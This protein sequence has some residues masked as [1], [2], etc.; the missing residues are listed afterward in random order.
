MKFPL[1]IDSNRVRQETESLFFERLRLYAQ[2]NL[3]REIIVLASRYRDS[4]IYADS[5][6]ADLIY[7]GF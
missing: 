1:N 2:E 5:I 6:Y 3:D 4:L 7:A